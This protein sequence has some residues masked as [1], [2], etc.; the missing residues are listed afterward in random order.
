ME[1]LFNMLSSSARIDKSKR[2]KKPAA[3]VAVAKKQQITS[4]H[5]HQESHDSSDD[6]DHS[7]DSDDDDNSHDDDNDSNKQSK[8]AKKKNENKRPP[9]QHSSAKLLQIH[10]EEINA[11]RRRMGIR[12]SNDNRNDDSVPDPISS[13]KDWERPSWWSDGD[14]DAK[15]A[16]TGSTNT[17]ATFR[18]IHQTILSNIESGRWVEPTPIQMQSLP[19][20]T[21]RRDVMGC[22]PTGSGKTGAFVLPAMLLA[23]CP[24]EV[25]YGNG[26]GGGGSGGNN[27]NDDDKQTNNKKQKNNNNN[28]NN[29]TNNNNQQGT[30]RTILLAPSRELASVGIFQKIFFKN[31]LSLF[32]ELL[33]LS[34]HEGVWQ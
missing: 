9:K 5:Y 24:E 30:I 12:L 28:N 27:N 25:Y 16:S 8:A 32:K 11:F 17:T 20:L 4:S 21:E 34:F 22:A 33:A 14:A 1:D 13:F 2:K 3:V 10:K 23:K 15:G 19:A 31:A 29:N 26:I 7:H 18:Q 6:S